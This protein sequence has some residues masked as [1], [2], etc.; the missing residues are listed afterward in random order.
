MLGGLS[1]RERERLEGEYFEDDE[2]FEQMLIAEEELI[3]A[4]ARGELSAEQRVRFEEL[5]LSSPQTRERVQFAR[6]LAGAV[7]DARAAKTTLETK[8]VARPAFLAALRA[9]GA[10]LRFAFAGAALAAAVGFPWL[11]FER[12]RMSAELRQLR[13]ERAALSERTREMEQRAAVERARREELRA[14]LEGERARPTP[15]GG[16]QEDNAARQQR[17]SPDIGS[18]QTPRPSVISFVLTPGLVRGGGARTLPVPR[19]ASAVVLR[20]NVEAGAYLSYRAVIETADGRQVWR[21][22]SVKLRQPASSGGAINLPAV[23]ARDLPAGDYVL[24]LSGE[25]SDGGF[26]GVAEYSFRVVRK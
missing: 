25:R 6:V 1:E 14:Q 16:R 19:S 11:L 9:R 24:L 20:L 17:P 18:R 2:A 4:Y 3:D 26:E 22:P 7:S 15:E 8:S 12:A 5:F 10:A 21:A 13:G 23:P